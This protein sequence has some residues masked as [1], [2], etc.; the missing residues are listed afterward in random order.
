MKTVD[1][2]GRMMKT[3]ELI[4]D[5][6]TDTLTAGFMPIPGR[7]VLY[8]LERP[9]IPSAAGDGGE[10]RISCIPEGSYYVCRHYST[11]WPLSWI[12]RNPLNGVFGTADEM[13]RG[14]PWGRTAILIHPANTVDELEGCIALGRMRET[15][16]FPDM[17]LTES[18]SALETL[19][20]YVGDEPFRLLI[21]SW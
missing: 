17:R 20:R 10:R 7:P 13:A 12:L 5:H 21:S 19:Y 8:T 14:Q 16:V 9:W 11:R 1:Q 4:R 2:Q 15:A 6:K 18:R 3:I